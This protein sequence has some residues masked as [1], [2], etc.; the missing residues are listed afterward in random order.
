[1]KITDNNLVKRLCLI[2]GFFA[3][4]LTVRTVVAPPEVKVGVTDDNLKAFLCQMDYWDYAQAGG[5]SFISP[6]PSSPQNNF[7][8][9]ISI[10]FPI[11]RRIAAV[12]VGYQAVLCG[13]E[14]PVRV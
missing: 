8:P 4:Y 2:V 12:I 11:D 1:M 13:A 7:A 14:S 6:S 10:F 3:F 9:L 5:K